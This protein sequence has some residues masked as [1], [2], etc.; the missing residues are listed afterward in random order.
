[1]EEK[2]FSQKFDVKCSELFKVAIDFENFK[3]FC[4]NQIKEIKIIKKYDT[5]VETEEILTFNT[6][7]KNSI[8]K[9]KTIHDVEPSKK[10]TSKIIEGPFKGTTVKIEFQEIENQ[11]NV[12]VLGDIKVSLRYIV[13]KPII[14][15]IQ[16]GIIM[17]L[18]YQMK[19]SIDNSNNE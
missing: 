16:K 1:M 18:I 2:I 13:L 11:T 19:N 6:Y 10:I 9:Q 3:T 4:P 5:K 12:N 7:F 8:I 17:A 14:K 15:K